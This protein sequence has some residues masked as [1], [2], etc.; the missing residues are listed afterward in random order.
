MGLAKHDLSLIKEWKMFVEHGKMPKN[1]RPKVL[2]SWERCKQLQ[3]DPYGGKSNII[4]TKEELD[5]KL[6]ENAKLINVVRPFMNMLYQNIERAGYSVFLADNEG[7][8]LCVLANTEDLELTREF[9]FIIGASWS[10]RAVGTTAVSMVIDRRNAVPFMSEEKYCF[11]LKTRACTAVP[12]K[13]NQGEIILILGVA[14]D[15]SDTNH[16]IFGTLLA[17]EMAIENKLRLQKITEEFSVINDNYKR[18]FDSISDA[19]VVVDSRGLIKDINS[20]AKKLLSTDVNNVIERNVEEVLGF[21]PVVLKGNK[22]TRGQEFVID[23][24]EGRSKYHIEK[25]I[26]IL[27]NNGVVDGCA[28]IIN[29]DKKQEYTNDDNITKNVKFTFKDI[30]GNSKEIK[31][32][33]EVARIAAENCYNVLITGK[34]GTGKELFAQAIHNA[35]SRAKGPFIAINCGAIPGNLVESELFGYEGGAFTGAVRRGQAGKF[36]LASGG[37]I[38]LDEIG[39]MPKGLQIKLLRVVQE[40]QIMRIGGRKVIPVDVRIIAATN[41]DLVKEVE[42]D[43]FREDLYWRLN[44]IDIYIPPLIERKGDISLLFEHFL[45]KHSERQSIEYIIDKKTLNILQKYHWP[46]NVRELENVVQ[47]I[48]AFTESNVILPEHLPKYITSNHSKLKIFDKNQSLKSVEKEVIMNAVNRSNG[49]LT[50]TAKQLGFSRSTLYNKLKK[51]NI[52]RPIN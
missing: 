24:K 14:A 51:Y 2:E 25:V 30:I 29:K 41:K 18:I 12:I 52:K 35:S 26:P 11:G 43:N 45:K 1:V 39:E 7:N 27:N 8:L 13:N 33:I 46:G 47:R 42:Q 23:L 50:M 49:N 31:E 48:L 17:I 16:Q 4:L 15:F 37:T 9:N 34:S 44:V 38:L 32:V 36:E 20:K 6:K 3:I 21:S 22:G 19:I 40:K 10:E 28:N 5:K